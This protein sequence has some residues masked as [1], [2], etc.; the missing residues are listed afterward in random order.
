MKLGFRI[1]SLT[2]RVAA[3]ASVKPIISHNLGYKAPKGL[4]WITNPKKAMYNK[5]YNK[6]SRGCLLSGVFLL[7][8]PVALVY[9]VWKILIS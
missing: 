7:S 5:I 6:T 9:V 2:K 8:M 1:P 3:R 4:G